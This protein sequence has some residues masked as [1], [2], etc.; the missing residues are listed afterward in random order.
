[1]LLLVVIG[2]IILGFCDPV[3]RK[4]KD[5]RLKRIWLKIVKTPI[6]DTVTNF[7]AKMVSKLE[8]KYGQKPN[9]VPD[10]KKMYEDFFEKHFNL[11]VYTSILL[12]SVGLI[13]YIISLFYN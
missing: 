4:S 9:E 12:I 8:K 10:F 6:Y 11:L 5:T 13:C 3:I 7:Q 1:M 2:F